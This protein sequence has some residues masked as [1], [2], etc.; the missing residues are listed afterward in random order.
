[1]KNK[2]IGF[3]SAGALVC[4]FSLFLGSGSCNIEFWRPSWSVQ[5]QFRGTKRLP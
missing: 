2:I 4:A 1:M 5:S 3:L